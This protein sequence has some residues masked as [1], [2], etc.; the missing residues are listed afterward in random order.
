M[1]C[2]D[3]FGSPGGSQINSRVD[4]NNNAAI[5][6]G[7]TTGAPRIGITLDDRNKAGLYISDSKKG[8][9]FRVEKK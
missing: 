1:S 5:T 2:I 3:L 7:P 4:L 8:E 9:P 6:I